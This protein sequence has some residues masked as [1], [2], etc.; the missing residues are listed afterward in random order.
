MLEGETGG[1][2]AALKQVP[3]KMDE[4]RESLGHIASTLASYRRSRTLHRGHG[5]PRRAM[6][7][8]GFHA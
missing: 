8:S 7:G 3:S 4:L 1:L 6:S 5:R 2:P